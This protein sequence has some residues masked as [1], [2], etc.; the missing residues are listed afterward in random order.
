VS[1]TGPADNARYLNPSSVTLSASASGPELNDILQKVE[2]FLNGSL[3]GTDTEQPWSFS[4]SGLAPG[5]YTL[6]A[7]ATDSQ[8]A[9]STSSPRT[10]VVSTTNAPPTVSIVTPLDNAKWHAPAGFM[11]QASASSGEANDTVTVQFYLNGTLQGSDSTSPYSINLHRRTPTPT[12][13]TTS[14]GSPPR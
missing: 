2:F 6:T 5:T 14:T 7:V 4:A 9:Q 11:F 3:V 13:T 10:L 8:G 1:L 12:A